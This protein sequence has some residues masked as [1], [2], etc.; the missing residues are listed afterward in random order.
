MPQSSQGGLVV[1][2]NCNP[3][4]EYFLFGDCSHF[5]MAVRVNSQ[6]HVLPLKSRDSSRALNL[7]VLH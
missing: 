7:L 4:V 5:L 6:L 2:W 3:F 1:F